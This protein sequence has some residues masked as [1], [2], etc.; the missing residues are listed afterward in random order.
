MTPDRRIKVTDFGIARAA[1]GMALTQTG[2]VM[3]T[4]AYISPEQ[5]EGTTAT[6][7][8]D[9]YSL[10]VVAFECLA[11]RKPFVADTPVGTAI[12]HLRN[13]VPDLPDTVPPT[14]RPSYAVG[15]PSR[16]GS[17]SPTVP[18]SPGRCVPPLGYWGGR[19]HRSSPRPS[20]L[21]GARQR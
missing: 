12:A 19:R 10:A 16:P 5:A 3:G 4:P 11:G 21:R 9:V 15:W 18:R 6:A 2:E 7:A 17:A 14:S 13:P 1:E 20:H 8:S